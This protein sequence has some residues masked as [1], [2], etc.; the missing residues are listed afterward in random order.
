MCG[1]DRQRTFCVCVVFLGGRVTSQI[2]NIQQFD[3]IQQ[4]GGQIFG[5]KDPF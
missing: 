3:I 1:Y 5:C 4:N 2:Q